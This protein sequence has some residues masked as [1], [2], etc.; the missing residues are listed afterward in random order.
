MVQFGRVV[1][2][3]FWLADRIREATASDQWTD[4]QEQLFQMLLRLPDGARPRWVQGVAKVK[5]WYEEDPANASLLN[6]VADVIPPTH[7]NYARLLDC[8]DGTH[9]Q[10]TVKAM[11][12]GEHPKGD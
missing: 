2:K 7:D 11:L 6:R 10:M 12:A 8:I 3:A 1:E 4:T 5:A 9:S